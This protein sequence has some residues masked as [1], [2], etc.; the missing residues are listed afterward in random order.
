MP[1]DLIGA[2]VD[3]L[4]IGW[5]ALRARGGTAAARTLIDDL[6][7]LDRIRQP[8]LASAP[9]RVPAPARGASEILVALVLAVAAFQTVSCL[10]LVA[11]AS[12]VSATHGVPRPSRVVLAL[13]FSAGALVVRTAAARDR[14][15]LGVVAVLACVAA[16]FARGST[17]G[18][19]SAAFPHA[20][21]VLRWVLPIAFAP[22]ALW[23]FAL[24]FPLVDRFTGLD[25]LARRAA[26]GAWLLGAVLFATI[27]SV[28]LGVL[29]DTFIVGRTGPTSVFWHLLALAIAPAIVVVAVRSRHAAHA[30]GRRIARFALALAAGITPFLLFGLLRMAIPPVDQWFIESGSNGHLWIDR[31][32]LWPLAAIPVLSCGALLLDRPLERQVVP[33]MPSRDQVASTA[34]FLILLTP[35]AALAVLVHELRHVRLA[36]LPWT[37]HR[38]ELLFAGCGSLLA[39]LTAAWRIAAGTRVLLPATDRW[40]LSNAIERIRLAR[41]EREIASVLAEEIVA[42]MAAASGGVLFPTSHGSFVDPS[43]G[44]GPLRGDA[45]LAAVF[46]ETAGPL[47]L[48]E[49]ALRALLPAD[50]RLWAAAHGIEM[51]AALRDREGV[52]IA[53]LVFGRKPAGRFRRRD[54]WLAAT[55]IAAAAAPQTCAD[56]PVRPTPASRDPHDELAFEC[57]ACGMVSGSLCARCACGA[58]MAVGALPRRLGATFA[59]ERRLAS[60][61]MGVVYQ[62]HDVRLDRDVALK[63]VP[64]LRRETAARLRVEARSMA[65]LSHEGVATLYGIE[66]WRATPVLV[67]EYLPGGT[68]AARL[69]AGPMR[70]LDAVT[71]ACRIAEALA[72]VHERG[73]LHGDVKPGN[74]AFTATGSPKLLDF[75]LAALIGSIVRGHGGTPGYLPPEAFRFSV[76]TPS[77]DLWALTVTLLNAIAGRDACSAVHRPRALAAVLKDVSQRVPSMRQRTAL[78]A[79][80][81]RALA[82]R[83]EARFATTLDLLAALRALASL[84]GDDSRTDP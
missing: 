38:W 69:A 2:F 64:Q 61:G 28:G 48:S 77:V 18:L 46:R 21:L 29:R 58:P 78:R 66:F 12:G 71:M 33:G 5:T 41:G 50:E 14:R 36:D 10:A 31:L 19:A 11:A 34:L 57:E 30:S 76:V 63:T 39:L 80:F 27:L 37:P 54:Q 67:T 72:Y 52:P 68:L 43:G 65:A 82:R 20:Q 84:L 70:P 55:L 81:E 23:H 59:I 60:G 49:H 53:I 83:P 75:G 22:A 73:M 8:A 17:T 42:G 32:V 1:A 26:T 74:I 13:A 79:F 15:S 51:A 16:A 24:A 7:L 6:R 45:A 40:R 9:E 44:V 4:P 47:D 3:R 56:D 62:A 35:V 25:V